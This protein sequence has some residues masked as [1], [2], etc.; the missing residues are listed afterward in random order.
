MQLFNM[1]RLNLKLWQ[2]NAFDAEVKL[3]SPACEVCLRRD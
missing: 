2:G 3:R 1:G